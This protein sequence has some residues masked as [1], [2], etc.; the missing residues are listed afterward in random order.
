MRRHHVNQ[1]RL[2]RLC[3]FLQGNRDRFIT[4]GLGEAASVPL[5]PNSDQNKLLKGNPLHSISRMA[6]QFVYEKYG[7]WRLALS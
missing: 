2:T 4:C 6:E 1:N 7:N 5:R 3:A